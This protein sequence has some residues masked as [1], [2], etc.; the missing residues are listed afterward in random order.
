MLHSQLG[1]A[2]LVSRSREEAATEFEAELKINSRDFNSNFSLGRIYREDG[3]LD[4]A[5]V[6]L[7][8]ALELRPDDVP[9]LYEMA[10]V[11][12]SK[13][14]NDEAIRLLERV[15]K[16]DPYLTAAHVLLARLY[17]KQHRTIDAERERA[18]I[19]RLNAEEQRLYQERQKKPAP[20]LDPGRGSTTTP[21]ANSAEKPSV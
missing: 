11:A 15:I 14:G 17:Y 3:R 8:K 18:E 1:T 9:T 16:L 5:L 21:P 10:H 4:E 6:L 7:K 19:Q 20:P 13:G 2:Y 12:Q